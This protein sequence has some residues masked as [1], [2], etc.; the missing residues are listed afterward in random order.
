MKKSIVTLQIFFSNSGTSFIISNSDNT[1]Y[2][3]Y[4]FFIYK[5]ELRPTTMSIDEIESVEKEHFEKVISMDSNIVYSQDNIINCE[6]ELIIPNDVRQTLFDSCNRIILFFRN[7][8]F[9]RKVK[10]FNF[11]IF[12]SLN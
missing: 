2:V 10:F 6:R 4:E 7:F 11:S 12:I 9:L 3:M 1:K 5:I 8:S